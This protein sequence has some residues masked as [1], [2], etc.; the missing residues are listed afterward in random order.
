MAKT[1]DAWKTRSPDDERR[2]DYPPQRWIT[3][4]ECGGEGSIEKP[5]PQHDDPYFC[6][7]KPCPACGAAGGWLDDVE[8]DANRSHQ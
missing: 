1:Y 7:V 3:C 6:E 2:D 5:N 8:P 4:D